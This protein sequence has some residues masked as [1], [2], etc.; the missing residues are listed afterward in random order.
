M[1]EDMDI[2]AII[3][4]A[5]LIARGLI[6]ESEKGIRLSEKGYQLMRERWMDMS[7][8]DKLLMGVFVKRLM[9]KR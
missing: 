2:V 4:K 7:N 1:S 3:T 5:N 8:E 9:E 6:E